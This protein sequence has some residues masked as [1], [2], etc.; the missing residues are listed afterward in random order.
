MDM[1]FNDD[2]PL[3]T[4]VDFEEPVNDENSP[5]TEPLKGIFFV[6]LS[7]LI[8]GILRSGAKKASKKSVKKGKKGKKGKNSTYAHFV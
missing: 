7:I 3:E 1:D 4:D 5:T 6:M 8:A 2:A